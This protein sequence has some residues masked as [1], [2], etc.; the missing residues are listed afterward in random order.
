LEN[1][2]RLTFLRTI[3][4]LVLNDPQLLIEKLLLKTKKRRTYNHT[5]IF[6]P[7]RQ[8]L[9]RNKRLNEIANNFNLYREHYNELNFEDLKKLNTIWYHMYPVQKHFDFLFVKSCVRYLIKRL[10]KKDLFVAELG[11]YQG[12]LA[13]EILK[14]FPLITWRNFDIIAHRRVCEL[15][16]YDYEETVLTKPLWSAKIDLKNCDIFVMS[17]TIEHFNDEEAKRIFNM[18]KEFNVK[19]III[20]SPL[21]PNGQ[22]W[23][24][25]K[26]SHLLRLGSNQLKAILAKDYRLVKEISDCFFWVR[27]DFENR[28]PLDGNAL[29]F[30]IHIMPHPLF[31]ANSVL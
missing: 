13:Y 30:S 24:N 23:H 11:G 17:D 6:K 10:R 29:Q 9:I 26:G 14:S 31:C 21:T 15:T 19:S 20:K 28:L 22:T 7:D 1:Q 5:S 3:V 18:V 25:Y 4:Q 27:R 16:R 2:N 12:E 8:H